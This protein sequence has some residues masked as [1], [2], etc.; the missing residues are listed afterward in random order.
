[1][2]FTTRHLAFE[3]RR[4][5]RQTTTTVS[6]RATSTLLHTQTQGK[7]KINKHQQ[8]SLESH[9]AK[10]LLQQKCT[11]K[12][13]NNDIPHDPFSY[14]RH[15]HLEQEDAL[16]IDR[17]QEELGNFDNYRWNWFVAGCLLNGRRSYATNKQSCM[18]STIGD[19]L[20][21]GIIRNAYFT[22][23][24][25]TTTGCVRQPHSERSEWIFFWR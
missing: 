9:S 11:W 24:R 19:E 2:T 17:R 5:R 13:K 14:K 10:L 1:V 6:P 16:K 8:Q 12:K 3:L 25:R 18:L 15:Y 4:L 7:H 23:L 20:F 22:D 21:Y